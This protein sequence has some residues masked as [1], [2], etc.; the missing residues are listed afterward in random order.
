MDRDGVLKINKDELFNEKNSEK[1]REKIY[2]HFRNLSQ[3]PSKL[4]GIEDKTLK[5]LHNKAMTLNVEEFLNKYSKEFE[6][7]DL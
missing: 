7:N 2:G 5:F 6:I 3:V 1:S 4:F